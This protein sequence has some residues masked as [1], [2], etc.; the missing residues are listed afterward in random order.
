VSDETR[1]RRPKQGMTG[2]VL[3]APQRGACLFAGK[4]A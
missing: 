4:V 2:V 3:G 1:P